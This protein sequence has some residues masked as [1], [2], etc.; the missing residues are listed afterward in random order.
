MRALV[1]PRPRLA[2]GLALLGLAAAAVASV[3]ASSELRAS[4]RARAVTAAAEELDVRFRRQVSALEATADD[5]SKVFSDAAPLP[6]LLSVDLSP[7]ERA[8]AE[9][10]LAGAFE[11]VK[12]SLGG[13]KAPLGTR[14]AL[15][16]E[17]SD[18]G[19][20]SPFVLLGWADASGVH[21]TEL[22]AWSGRLPEAMLVAEHARVTASTDSYGFAW[23]QPEGPTEIRL[24]RLDA[25]NHSEV[26]PEGGGAAIE[27]VRLAE[28]SAPFTVEG[29]FGARVR[30]DLDEAGLARALPERVVP[31]GAR[32]SDAGPIGD[33]LRPVA[34]AFHFP[35]AASTP[36]A[37]VL[38][39]APG[40][41]WLTIVLWGLGGV[42]LLGA[43]AFA[44]LHRRFSGPAPAPDI[45]AE[46]AHELKT[47]LTAMRGELEVSLRRERTP[48]EY[49]DTIA[50]TLEEVK[51][52]QNLVASVLLLT[53]GAEAPRGEEPVDM[54]EVVKA[55]AERIHVAQPDRVV[56]L[57]SVAGPRN[58]TGDPS[59]L[60]RAVG[61]LLDNAVLH[62]VASGAIRIRCEAS[63]DELRLTVEDDGPGIPE[64]RREKVFE[65]FY[66]GPDVGQRGIPG[67]GLGL[68]IARWIA[69]VHGGS[70]VLDPSVEGRA[71]FVLSLP[72]ATSRTA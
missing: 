61:N 62:S 57:A 50:G 40:T 64:A 71:R 59:L 19:A 56:A 54:T 10:A 63:K 6:A 13:T 45:T 20:K 4:E 69:E 1:R 65:R 24:H 5:L 41:P 14:I 49:R 15:Y 67:S 36:R 23:F 21:R 33:A 70:L 39:E 58:V 12:A 8:K 16:E 17:A 42:L 25:Y 11:R 52:L 32:P 3:H 18:A 43:L 47:P 68:P 29:D 72:L 60:A 22:A 55:E 34:Y 30:C 44:G 2:L 66:R 35:D 51:G 9:R 26:D 46:A 27:A 48:A 38:V 37:R 31:G 28:V 7:T 53:R